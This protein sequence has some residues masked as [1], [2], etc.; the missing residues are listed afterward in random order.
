VI[1]SIAVLTVVVVG[2]AFAL[3]AA[4]SRSPFRSIEP[5]R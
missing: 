1:V 3:R 4:A 5:Q 2:L